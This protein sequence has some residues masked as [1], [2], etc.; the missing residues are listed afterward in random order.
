MSGARLWLLA[1]LPAL[2]GCGA[3]VRIDAEALAR[4]RPATLA[5]VPFALED[6]DELSSR[7]ALAQVAAI[8]AALAGEVAGRSWLVL[9]P[10]E[11]ERRL[12]RAGLD[13]RQA[14]RA[15][16]QLLARALGVDALLRG[17]IL[18]LSNFVGGVVYSQA[19]DGDVR[20][21][22][23]T[24]GEVLA[25]VRHEERSIGGVLTQST[26]NLRSIRDTLENSSDVGFVRLAASFAGEVARALPEPPGSPS[27]AQP[28]IES[29][30]V[31]APA[32]SLVEGD[33]VEIA[34]RASPGLTVTASAGEGR[35]P[36]LEEAPG[37]Y[38]GRFGIG[39]GVQV[40]GPIS[41]QAS[42]AFGL[43][44]LLVDRSRTLE[45]DT[46]PPAPPAGVTIEDTREGSRV[47][48]SAPEGRRAGWRVF[49][50]VARG[51]PD[52]LADAPGEAREALVPRRA[53]AGVAAV[54]DQGRLSSV[55]WAAGGAR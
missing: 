11:V 38:R 33:R 19:I 27:M 26:V 37:T 18:E 51:V 16:Y 48:W 22:D 5:V 43:G 13:R 21:V 14:S 34:V 20:L 17:R 44:A 45:I 41:A 6:D 50:V 1:L 49:G 40:S 36:L 3:A 39:R 47:T 30:Q 12:R 35:V 54:D 52:L 31:D 24:S 7:R 53:L 15:S 2:A 10:A 9:D 28:T 55:V 4:E 25:A 46:R 8:E 23:G 42:D 32:R 29:I